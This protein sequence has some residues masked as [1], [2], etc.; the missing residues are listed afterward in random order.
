MES[1]IIENLLSPGEKNTSELRAAGRNE[2]RHVPIADLQ[3]GASAKM[4][5]VKVLTI[6]GSDS[7]GGAGIQA[8][9]KTFSALGCFGTSVITAVTAQNTLGVKSVHAIPV[10]MIRDQLIAVLEDIKPSAIK[11][12]M[13]NKP[14]VAKLI[15]DVLV[16]QVPK[17]PVIL[18]PVMVATSG[19]RLIET[20]TVDTLQHELFPLATLVTPNIDEAVILA[21]QKIA[22]VEEMIEAA[23]AIINQG[24]HAVLLKGGHLIGATIYDVFVA[25]GEAPIVL[26]SPYIH[27]ANLHGTGCTL[28]SAIA[29]EMAKGNDLIH[30]IKFAKNYIASA[31]RAGA[32]V[33]T[34]QG[35]GPLNHFFEPLKLIMK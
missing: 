8:D 20:E 21:K 3:N 32:G 27:S 13:I 11:I 17:I 35:N 31:L 15:K 34:G 28:S 26:E 1:V 2:Q 33:K 14:E 18:D 25:K 30:A 12:G 29:A 19:H 6:A 5:Y 16:S 4:E 24:A 9:L 7:G 10:E 22:N 23:Y